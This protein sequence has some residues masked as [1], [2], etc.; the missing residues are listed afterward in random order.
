[1]KKTLFPFLML[2]FLIFSACQEK[3][4]VNKE[5]EAIIA[6]LNG[7]SEAYLAMDSTKWMSYWVQDELTLRVDAG[8]EDYSAR[9]WKQLHENMKANMEND[10]LLV[11]YK[12]MKFNKSDFNIKVH[13]DCAWAYFN[14]K[15]TATYKGEP[16]ETEDMQLRILEKVDGQWKIAF[17]GAI[18]VSSYAE[19]DEED[20][21]EETT[22]D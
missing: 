2:L 16:V 20:D 1:M 8:E 12:N 13:P 9:G 17:M 11:D 10:S 4:D 7:E 21:T 15:F 5:K 18:D 6:A 3:L 19:D 22:E 14:E